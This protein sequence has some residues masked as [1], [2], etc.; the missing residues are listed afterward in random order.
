MFVVK[1][2]CSERVSEWGYHGRMASP[3]IDS[4]HLRSAIEF[5]V[6]IAQEGQKFKPPMQYP[7]GLKKYMS[8][9]RIPTQALNGLRRLVERDDTF[10]TRVAAGAVPELVDPVGRLWLERPAGWEDQIRSLVA[11]VEEAERV[12]DAEKRL[13]KAEK[14]REAAERSATRAVAEV[15]GLREQVSERDLVIDGLRTDVVKLDDSLSELRAELID[16]RNEIRH[17]RDREA[18]AVDKLRAAETER[19]VANDAQELAET[20]RD[21]VLADRAVVA[22]ERSELARLAAA[23][24]SL[25]D[26]LAELAAPPGAG[27]PTKA[28][29]KSIPMPGGVMGDSEAAAEYLLKSGASVLVDG[30]NVAKLRWPGLDLEGQREVLLDATENLARRYGSDIT[31]VF[32]GADVVGASAG[33]RRIVRVVYSPD[34]VIADDVI[35][36]EVRRLPVT[37]QIVVVT[38]DREILT[39]VKSLGANTLASEQFVALMR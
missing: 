9:Q 2:T 23:A 30:Y 20:V 25:A 3:P 34:D 24:E 8:M 10:R 18:A 33:R 11:D 35:R 27:V 32:D 13:K 31:V 4:R 15:V 21:D 16:T 14:R 38:N 19:D 29:R 22:R 1:N 7:A 5:V 6:L 36:D 12:D 28:R 26:Q 39:D 37:R 17:A